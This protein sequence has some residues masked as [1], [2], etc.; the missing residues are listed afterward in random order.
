MLQEDGDA[1]H[2]ERGGGRGGEAEAGPGGGWGRGQDRAAHSQ[3]GR[4]HAALEWSQQSPLL[5][6]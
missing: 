1:D 2:E 6:K 4:R 5:L 3:P